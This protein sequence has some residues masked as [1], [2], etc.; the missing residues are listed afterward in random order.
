MS[1]EAPSEHADGLLLS[2]DLFFVSK[3]TGT[4]GALG[5]RVVAVGDAAKAADR[6]VALKPRAVFVDL[7]AGDLVAPTALAHYRSQA[8]GTPFVTFGS[9]VDTAALAAAASAGCDPVLPRSA[10]SSRLPELL[11]QFLSP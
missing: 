11:R 6:I 3:V 2:R 7:A 1:A 4:A 8:P 9:H 5:Y 10:F